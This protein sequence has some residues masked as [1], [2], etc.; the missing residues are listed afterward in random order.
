M[1]ERTEERRKGCLSGARH[2]QPASAIAA[3]AADEVAA[4]VAAAA[5]VAAEASR[6][7]TAVGAVAETAA[8]PGEASDRDRTSLAAWGSPV[9]A[10]CLEAFREG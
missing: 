1:E 10:S 8:A 9:A 4:A 3:V 6:I 5:G 7:R 2:P